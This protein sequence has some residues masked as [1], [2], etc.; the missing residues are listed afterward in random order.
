MKCFAARWDPDGCDGG[1]VLP[2]IRNE[3]T[4]TPGEGYCATH[5]ARHG[6]GTI[7]R[8]PKMFKAM[9]NE[10][11]PGHRFMSKDEL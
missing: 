9:A 1:L 2:G 10:P 7:V 8:R 11:G 6:G 5:R 4:D 3:F